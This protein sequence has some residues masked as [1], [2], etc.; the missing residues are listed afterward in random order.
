VENCQVGVFLSYVTEKGHALIDRDLYVPEDW[1]NDRER[2]RGAG[3]DESVQCCL[4]WELA[5]HIL[6]RATEAGITFRWVVADSVYGQAVELRIW[7]EKHA[8]AYVLGIPCDE[9]VCVKT[10]KG[11]LLAE[12]REICSTLI[13]EQD[14]HRLPM[15]QGGIGPRMFDWAL[16]PMMHKG[17]VDGQ[18]FLLIRRCIDDPQEKSYYL[19]FA[20]LTTTLQEMV[21]AIGARWH[22]EENLEETFDLGLDQYEVRSS[23]G[24]YRHYSE[25]S[26]RS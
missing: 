6:K 25:Y 5:L 15:S 3:I 13:K 18:H 26:L 11:Y 24:W 10:P 20:P 14:W 7:L 9:A 4:K 22:I 2:C 1:I 19:V 16:L 17:V 21:L 23:T 12:A 8:I